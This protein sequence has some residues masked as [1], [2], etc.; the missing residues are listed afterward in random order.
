MA[1]AL[2]GAAFSL[3][4]PGGAL[5]GGMLLPAMGVRG[6]ALGGAVLASAA[7]LVPLGGH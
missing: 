4:I 7:T 6:T 3:G 2:G 1:S 5:L